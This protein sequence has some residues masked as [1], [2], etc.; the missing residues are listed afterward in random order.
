MSST[1]ALAE[2]S[3]TPDFD[4]VYRE[5]RA[6]KFWND[7]HIRFSDLDAL[8]HLS[9]VRT[10]E[11]FAEARAKLFR[12]AI[13]GWPGGCPQVPVLKTSL[14][15]FEREGHYPAPISMGVAVEAFGRTSFRLVMAV[16]EGDE[17]L[18]LSRNVFVFIDSATRAPVAPD[19]AIVEA[20]T[21]LAPAP[22]A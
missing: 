5:R 20:F 3:R 15:T 22:G 21:R 12:T 17:C 9:S 6:Y 8:G 1:T 19:A 14:I 10:G 4:P 13:P 7:G 18:S 11:Y 2:K 16:F